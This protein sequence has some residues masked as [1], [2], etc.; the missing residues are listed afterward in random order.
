[1]DIQQIRTRLGSSFDQNS[2]NSLNVFARFI[3]DTDISKQVNFDYKAFLDK[4][5]GDKINQILSDFGNQLEFINRKL[6]EYFKIEKHN[7][8]EIDLI[9]VN[10]TQAKED[11]LREPFSKNFILETP[12]GFGKT[13]LLKKIKTEINKK[14]NQKC[15]YF[16][17]KQVDSK[18][19]PEIIRQEADIR[20]DDIYQ[21]TERF[22]N[23]A[24][25]NEKFYV[26]FDHFEVLEKDVIDKIKNFIEY[27][28]KQNEGRDRKMYIILS[29]RRVDFNL[30]NF[31]NK[32]NI[33]LE[34][35][36]DE[37]IK[38][39]I[40]NDYEIFKN[41]TTENIPIIDRF[42]DNTNIHTFIKKI[43][44]GHPGCI[45][46]F[47]KN[48]IH[49]KNYQI[50]EINKL[51][52]QKSGLVKDVVYPAIKEIIEHSVR[53]NQDR[54][55]DFLKRIFEITMI[56][57]IFDLATIGLIQEELKTYTELPYTIMERSQIYALLLQSNLFVKLEN[58]DFY[59]DGIARNLFLQNLINENDSTDEKY[60]SFEQINSIAIGIYEKRIDDEIAN[61]D[62]NSIELF[63]REY[64]YHF[65]LHKKEALHQTKIKDEDKEELQNKYNSIKESFY[66]K[67][68][69]YTNQI[70]TTSSEFE[71]KT[72][73]K[74]LEKHNN[75]PNMLF[76]NFEEKT[77]K[78]DKELLNLFIF[79]NLNF[80][81]FLK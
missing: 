63:F 73:E 68:A 55:T 59:K 15:Y 76:N 4:N 8:D 62:K 32:K 29:G 17:L 25:R 46:S 80:D 11:I 81:N 23:Q 67:V 74:L 42:I 6:D 43:T 66:K 1:M 70:K 79:F 5:Y 2:P 48:K 16:D 18:T 50:S 44:A 51:K 35:F 24:E 7:K 64:I 20:G 57:R 28:L 31:Y 13:W 37:V 3:S 72:L 39:A 56:F 60:I 27:I 58:T 65:L 47:I 53:D 41:N 52:E 14:E 54:S 71:K 45:N 49:P 75:N 30:Y 26:I 21:V 69:E 36:S 34:E 40:K 9:F 19:L 77:M 61:L 33:K 78:N 10:Q 12:A 38:Q 22:Y